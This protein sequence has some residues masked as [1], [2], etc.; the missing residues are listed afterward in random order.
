MQVGNNLSF[1]GGR[2][3]AVEKRNKVKARVIGYALRQ[4][5]DQAD[6]VFVMGHKN[7]DMDSFGAGIG[8]LRAVKDREKEG[9]LVLR[10]KT[11]LLK[12]FMKE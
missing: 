9:Y 11:H 6:R 8:V 7:P 12:I 10:E 2:T 5:I 3:K 1:Y 4:L